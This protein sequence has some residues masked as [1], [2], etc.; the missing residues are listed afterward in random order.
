MITF[1]CA[2]LSRRMKGTG[3]VNPDYM[4]RLYGTMIMGKSRDLVNSQ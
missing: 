4:V 2:D 3:K 1:L